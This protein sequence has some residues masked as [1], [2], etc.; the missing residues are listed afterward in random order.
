MPDQASAHAKLAARV[1]RWNGVMPKPAALAKLLADLDVRVALVRHGDTVEAWGH[2]GLGEPLRRL[3][4][5][6]GVRPLS[7]AD[8]L[9]ALVA[10]RV[11]TWT[12][13]APDPDQPLLVETAADRR[14]RDARGKEEDTPT[15]WWVYATVGAALLAGGVIIYSHETADNTQRVELHFP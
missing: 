7:E 1:S 10:D 4:D 12:D 11:Q 13:R 15:K 14:A 6:D 5:D 2:A 8:A 3:G 9:V